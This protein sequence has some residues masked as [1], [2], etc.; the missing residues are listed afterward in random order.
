M[1]ENANKNSMPMPPY[2]L[3][4]PSLA[5]IPKMTFHLLQ[6]TKANK[7]LIRCFVLSRIVFGKEHWKCAQALANLA[8][9]YLILRGT[10]FPQPGFGAPAWEANLSYPLGAGMTWEDLLLTSTP[11]LI[12]LEREKSMGGGDSVPSNK[13]ADDDS[14]Y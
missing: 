4:G 8:Y 6:S 14:S 7:E 10:W 9:G 2:P 12:K 11:H 3:V 13:G 1:R 5:S